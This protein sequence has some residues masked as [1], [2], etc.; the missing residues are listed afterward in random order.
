[1]SSTNSE[2]TGALV[3]VQG[4]EVAVENGFDVVPA[5]V[6]AAGEQASYRFLEFFAARIRNPNTRKAYRRNALHFFSWA[7]YRK[8][9]LEGVT[10]VHVAAYMA[11]GLSPPPFGGV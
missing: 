5:V 6:V 7:E 8:L 3:V 1:M 9:S 2:G 10:S 11:S 4:G